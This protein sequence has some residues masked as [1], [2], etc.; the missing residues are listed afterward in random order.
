MPNYFVQQDFNAPSKSEVDESGKP[1]KKLFSRGQLII[2]KKA[3]YT[4]KGGINYD[5]V[6]TRDGYNI[7]IDNVLLYETPTKEAATKEV[8]LANQ[9][10]KDIANKDF[11]HD[12]VDI[13]QKS[14]KGVSYGAIAGFAYAFLKGKSLIWCGLIGGISGGLAG[15]YFGKK[16]I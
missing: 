6:E 5:V 13:S 7:P 9:S 14:M 16:A 4:N 1:I 15:Y 11:V 12:L 3:I 2:A 10:I 8:E